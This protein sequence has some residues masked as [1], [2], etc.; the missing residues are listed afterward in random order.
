MKSVGKGDT[1]SGS[2][3]AVADKVVKAIDWDYLAKV[4]VSAEGKRELSALRRAYDEASNVLETKLNVKPVEIKWDMYRQQLGSRI[5]DIFQKS[6][7][8]L[9][10]PEY[11]D[12][13]TPAFQKEHEQLV[14]QATE[15]Q[16]FSK[17]EVVRLKSELES[18]RT[19]KE[20][21]KNQTVD[22]YLAK[23]PDIKTKIDKEIEEGNWGY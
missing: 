23:H 18:L 21:L 13:Y 8:T 5:V 22:D 9:D 15:E 7:E 12:K 10:V 1:M 17:K 19:E 4:I 16:D 6:Y 3:K 14:A 20:S 2:G 11:E